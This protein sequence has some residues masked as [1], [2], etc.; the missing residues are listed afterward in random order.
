MMFALG[1]AGSLLDALQSLT[2]S[3]SSSAT[4]SANPSQDA[5]NPFDLGGSTQTQ[6]PATT[7]MSGQGCGWASISPQTMSALIDAQAQS[8]STN[9]APANPSDALQ[10]LFSQID[11]NG[12]G[13]IDKSEFESAL[14]AGGTNLAAADDVF[15]KLDSNGDGSVSLDELKSALQGA[16][17]HS[18]HHHMRAA[19][20]SLTTDLAADLTASDGSTDP[21]TDSSDNNSGDANSSTNQLRHLALTVVPNPSI[22]M[23]PIDPTGHVNSAVL[24]ARL[25]QTLSISV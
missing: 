10:D 16:G 23:V 2:S 7:G 14:G 22:N 20:S 5:A 25:N 11:G 18:H 9:S 6:S 21:S 24:D 1:A 4:T 12:D 17:H 15:S 8:G 3:K 19:S 13:S